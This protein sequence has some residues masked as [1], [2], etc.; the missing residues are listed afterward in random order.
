[1]T[2]LTATYRSTLLLGLC[3]AAACAGDD[4]DSD[5]GGDSLTGGIGTGDTDASTG[6]T[7]NATGGDSVDTPDDTAD[8]PDDTGDGLCG[9]GVIDD[10]EACDGSVLR[11]EDCASQGYDEGSLACD[12]DCTAL[13]TSECVTWVCGNDVIEGSEVCDGTNVDDETCVSQRFDGGEIACAR[14]CSALNVDA[15]VLFS[16][17]ND[18]VE[19]DEVCD[20][21]DLDRETCLSQGFTGGTLACTPNCGDF[22]TSACT[23][24][25]DEQTEGEEVCDGSDLG[26]QT[27]L[28]NDFQTGILACATDCSDY[29]LS[30][31]NTC[32]NTTAEGPE[33]CDGDDVQGET[34]ISQGFDTGTIGCQESCDALDTS[35]CC[36]GQDIGSTVGAAVATGTNLGGG[37]DSVGVCD[38]SAGPD[39]VYFWTAPASQVF[40]I[41]TLGSDYNTVLYVLDDCGGNELA[42]N[43]QASGTDQSSVALSA[44]EGTTYAI[45]VDGWDGATGNHRVNIS[46]SLA[47]CTDVALGNATGDPV[48]TGDNAGAGDDFTLTPCTESSGDDVELAWIAPTTGHYR[49]HTIGSTFDTVLGLYDGCGG[50]QL[51]CDDQGGGGGLSSLVMPVTAGVP[52][53][54]VV[55]GW[56]D[57]SGTF[58]L[59]IEPQLSSCNDADLGAAVGL[60]IGS[61]NNLGANDDTQPGCTATTGQDVA[62]Q[63]TAPSTD[64]FRIDTFGSDFDTV[65]YVRED[66]G[67]AELVCNNQA[68]GGDQSQVTLAATAGTTY[69][70]VVDGFG[71]TGNISLAIAPLPSSCVDAPTAAT[72]GPA[73]ASGTTIGAGDNEQTGCT[74]TAAEDVVH[75]W[76]APA[77]GTYALDTFGS[78]FDTVLEVRSS[79]A[80][81]IVCNDQAGGVG[82]QSALEFEATAGATYLMVVDGWNGDAGAYTLNINGPY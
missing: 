69:S 42:C 30:G 68:G 40:N 56:N 12:D 2:C 70:I 14:D 21:T 15:C 51:S 82:P 18:M 58:A 71:E 6:P 45:V 39:V 65:L 41:D 27:C 52:Y 81:A 24:C 47:A 37:D 35:G 11:G 66:C 64:N 61:G 33:V 67:G 4:T 44:T 62:F 29:D 43:D 28:D 7:G 9:N 59:A 50:A 23:T 57:A 19:G 20:G 34:C 79:C 25:G 10:D 55:D 78:D 60:G 38:G 32:G 26:G 13:D 75:H 54:V 31:C 1:M 49:F 36:S 76:I 22:E 80:S 46:A 48:A 3:L 5:S 73:I 8:T 63:W 74:A 17:A 72:L 53:V 77:S 16:C